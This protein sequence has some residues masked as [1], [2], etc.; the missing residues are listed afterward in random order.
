[1]YN[2]F[3]INFRSLA[4]NCYTPFKLTGAEAE[5][6]QK[7]KPVRV[8]RSSKFKSSKYAPK[9]GI[10]YDG[11][12]KVQKYYRIMGKSGWYVWRYVLK[13][14]DLEPAPW[15]EGGQEYP[16]VVSYS[17][18]IIHFYSVLLEYYI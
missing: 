13:R 11:I 18:S 1:M 3:L 8:L 2:C 15:A 14:D 5:E 4:I 6:W 17:N 9:D 12:Y 16:I 7:G 10:R